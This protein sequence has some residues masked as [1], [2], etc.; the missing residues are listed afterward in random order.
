MILG[1]RDL[2]FGERSAGA[3]AVK[4]CGSNKAV[5]APPDH[6]FDQRSSLGYP[7]G[8]ILKR[9]PEELAFSCSHEPGA[10]PVRLGLVTRLIAVKIAVKEDL[11]AGIGPGAKSR[12]ERRTRD[13]RS[14]APMV[15][16]DQHREPIAD[17]RCK[18]IDELIDLALEARRDIVDGC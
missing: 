11:D 2:A 17:E 13:D 7:A 8:R 1:N 18:Q 15:G 5:D 14:P 12:R 10:Q 6:I 16:Y 9:E 4:P 3:F